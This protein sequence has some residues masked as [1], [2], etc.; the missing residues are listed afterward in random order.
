MA[1]LQIGQPLIVF[2]VLEKSAT[3][4]SEKNTPETLPIQKND[5]PIQTLWLCGGFNPPDSK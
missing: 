1:E 4:P 3:K 2:L 5:S